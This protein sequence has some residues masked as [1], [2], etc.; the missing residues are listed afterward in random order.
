[1]DESLARLLAVVYAVFI[2]SAA[3]LIGYW[4]HLR[5]RR[6][7]EKD[8]LAAVAELQLQLDDYRSTLSAEISDLHERLDFAERM[9]VQKEGRPRIEHPDNTPV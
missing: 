2:P 5:S 6:R 8:H 4:M 9:L 7:L 1:M 3:G